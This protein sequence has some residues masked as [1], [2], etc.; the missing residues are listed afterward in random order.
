MTDS[1]RFQNSIRSG[2]GRV[3]GIEW[4]T[5]LSVDGGLRDRTMGN[6]TQL[7]VQALDKRKNLKTSESLR[8]TNVE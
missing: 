3:G 7:V 2:C 1:D 6:R 5:G 8:K 4:V